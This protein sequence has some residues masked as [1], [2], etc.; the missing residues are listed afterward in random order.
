MQLNSHGDHMIQHAP[1]PS[2]LIIVNNKPRTG[3]TSIIGVDRYFV[4]VGI[5]VG[6]RLVLACSFV[7]HAALRYCSVT[8][9]T[10]YLLIVC[11]VTVIV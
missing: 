8:Y 9:V 3:G 5:Y 1:C 6:S 11:C 2:W 7:W 4:A 10:C